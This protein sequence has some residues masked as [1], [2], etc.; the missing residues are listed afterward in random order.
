MVKNRGGPYGGNMHWQ[1][2][3][4]VTQEGGRKYTA[5]KFADLV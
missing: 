4:R 5:I 2:A 1:R 3:I